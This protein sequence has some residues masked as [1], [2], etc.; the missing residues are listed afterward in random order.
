MLAPKPPLQV[1][2]FE[3]KYPEIW[4]DFSEFTD[5]CH[6]GGPLDEKSRRILKIGISIGAGLEGGLH[7]AV[8]HA[9]A[10]GISADEISHA[11]VLAISTIGFPASMRALTWIEDC[12][13]K[14][15]TP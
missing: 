6:D 11:A 7:S 15:E 8:R 10:A 9:L 4:K 1:Q 5:K 14:T 2:Q 12:I 3:G 13:V